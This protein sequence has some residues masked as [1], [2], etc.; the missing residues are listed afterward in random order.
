[1]KKLHTQALRLISKQIESNMIYIRENFD[2]IESEEYLLNLLNEDFFGEDD[3]ATILNMDVSNNDDI[4]YIRDTQHD[5]IKELIQ[6]Y[7]DLNNLSDEDKNEF[8]YINSI[9]HNNNAVAEY[10]LSSKK[11]KQEMINDYFKNK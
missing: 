2:E 6:L 3:A 7:N 8:K 11:E 5:S 9:M 10:F 4:D 1:M